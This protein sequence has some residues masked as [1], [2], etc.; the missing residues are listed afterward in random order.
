MTG[1]G[2][3]QITLYM[4]ALLL[5]AKPLGAYMARVY[6]GKHLPLLDAVLGPVERLLYRLARIQ[7]GDEMS[8]KKYAVAV[9]AF[10]LLSTVVVYSL[11]RVQHLLPLNPQ[12]QTAVAP[13][14]PG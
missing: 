9:L 4:A 10:S 3:L 5:L 2:L 8:W 11:Q 6:Q 12:G 13:K 14:G 7:P 1:S